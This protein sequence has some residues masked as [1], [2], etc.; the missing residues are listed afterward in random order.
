M[1]FREAICGRRSNPT[2]KERWLHGRRRAER[3]YSMF[4]VRKGGHEEIPLVQDKRNP[5]KTVA[6][7]APLSSTISYSLLKFMSIEWVML[8]ISSSA[9]LFSC[10]QS[11]P[12][13]FVVSWLFSSGGQ[14]IGALVSAPFLPIKI[15]G[16]FPLGL[17]WFDLLPHISSVQFSDSV[18][19]DSLRP[20]ESQHTRPP[21]PSPTPGVHPNPRPLNR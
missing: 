19:S 21:C 1:D 6:H 5:S 15:Q 4:K 20:H 12:G 18:M 13:S 9:T 16:C 7:Q 3:S 10:L 2:S 14:S 11:S 17:T 8:T